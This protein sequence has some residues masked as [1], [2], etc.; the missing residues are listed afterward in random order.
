MFAETGLSKN[1]ANSI[2]YE[3]IID[4][5]H[6]MEKI[7]YTINNCDD[8]KKFISLR[9][10]KG[11]AYWGD[12]I[13]GKS[14]R[15]YHSWLSAIPIRYRTND[16]KV[17]LTDGSVPLMDLSDTVPYDLN[18]QWYIDEANKLLEKME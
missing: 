1:P 4:Y 13:L 10:V 3:A 12:D 8:I 11:G 17:P 18:K 15:W 14:V 2:I 16:N 5:F 7:E 6:K 9:T